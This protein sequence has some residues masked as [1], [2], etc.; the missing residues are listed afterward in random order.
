MPTPSRPFPGLAFGLGVGPAFFL[1][2]TL[3]ANSW[4]SSGLLAGGVGLRSGEICM[5]NDCRTVS[6]KEL[7]ALLRDEKLVSASCAKER[8]QSCQSLDCDVST[9]AENCLTARGRA[10]GIAG[11]ITSVALALAILGLF[12]SGLFILLGRTPTWPISPTTISF[13]SLVVA[14][15]SGCVFAAMKPGPAK[16]FGISWGF[17]V[18]VIGASVAILGSLLMARALAPPVDDWDEGE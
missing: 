14:I 6:T 4:L 17:G 8:G 7:V 13:L 11:W 5:F 16:V 3:F 15:I 1:L 9:V 10:F 2:I 18:F 12:I